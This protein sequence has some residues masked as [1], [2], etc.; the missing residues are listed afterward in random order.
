MAD[1]C[2]KC[3]QRLSTAPMSKEEFLRTFQVG[4]VISGWATRK[5]VKITAIGSDRFLHVDYPTEPSD[6]ERVS[7]MRQSSFRWKK[8]PADEIERMYR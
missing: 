2:D 3:G 7:M 4:D 6:K 5:W 8:V 1:I